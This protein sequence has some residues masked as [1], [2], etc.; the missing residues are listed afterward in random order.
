MSFKAIFNRGFEDE[1][2]EC[3]SSANSLYEFESKE[4]SRIKIRKLSDESLAF[5]RIAKGLDVKGILKLNSLTKM[6]ASVS[7]LNAK[8]EYNVFMT[9]M[10]FDFPNEVSFVYQIVHDGKEVD[11]PTEIIITEKE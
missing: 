2:L 8:V 3:I 10:F 9:R 7:E 6:S 11:E 5:Q 4:G 1:I